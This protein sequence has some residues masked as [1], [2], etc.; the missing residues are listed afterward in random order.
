MADTHPHRISEKAIVTILRYHT[1][2][3]AAEN[4]YNDWV[5][6]KAVY[7][8]HKRFHVKFTYEQ[9]EE[10]VKANNRI[11]VMTYGDETWLKAT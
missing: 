8:S 5:K 2:E 9:F 1:T 7:R 10:V 6:A 3:F 4:R 11:E